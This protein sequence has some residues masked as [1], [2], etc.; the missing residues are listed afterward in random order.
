M[1]RNNKIIIS[2][3][4]LLLVCIF[5]VSNRVS[6]SIK[7]DGN[8]S[9]MEI[10]NDEH[11]VPFDK[12]YIKINGNKK[13][14]ESV[15]V[16]IGNEK[17]SFKVD[18]IDLENEPFFELPYYNENIVVGLKYWIKEATVR[19][20]DG[21]I[22]R[23]TTNKDDKYY[24]DNSYNYFVVD[25]FS[26]D[27][28]AWRGFKGVDF[29]DYIYSNGNIYFKVNG[30]TT[31]MVDIEMNFVSIDEKNSFKA[32][33][34]GFGNRTY[35]DISSENVKVGEE[36]YLKS[37]TIYY[38]NGGAYTYNA[39]NYANILNNRIFIS[40]VVDSK[41]LKIE[42]EQIT[43]NNKNTAINSKK[44]EKD[45]AGGFIILFLVIV[46]AFAVLFYLKDEE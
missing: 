29:S 21:K 17:T 36:Y 8:N 28:D 4:L 43:D 38:N 6:S 7:S 15:S 26:D 46:A 22:I 40:E 11:V 1:K 25:E 3:G 16:T 39:D 33:V 44:R 32:D 5:F 27:V 9:I 30:D 31:E 18:L 23:Y 34:E 37:M 12:V 35:F 2:V 19:Y 14:M 42:D 24:I 13:E 20:K 45:V 10:V 41:E